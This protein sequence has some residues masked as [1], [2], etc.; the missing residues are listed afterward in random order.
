VTHRQA[1]VR[2]FFSVILPENTR[3]MAVAMRLGFTFLEDKGDGPLLRDTPRDLAARAR[4]VATPDR[5]TRRQSAISVG[6]VI[7]TS[8]KCERKNPLSLVNN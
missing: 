8:S 7:L 1:R 5:E 3:S 2:Q 4:R 6:S